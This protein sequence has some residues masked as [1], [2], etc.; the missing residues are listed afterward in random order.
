MADAIRIGREARYR[1]VA[2][3]R[4]TPTILELGCGR[5]TPHSN[6]SPASTS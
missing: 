4:L 6:I 2:V 5:S 1:V 3:E